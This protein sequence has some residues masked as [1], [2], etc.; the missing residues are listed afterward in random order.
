MGQSARAM[1]HRN[2]SG[3][4]GQAARIAGYISS[5]PAPPALGGPELLP[6]YCAVHPVTRDQLLTTNVHE[7]G[8]LGYGEG[9]VIGHLIPAA[10]VTGRLGVS[11]LKMPW[12]SRFGERVRA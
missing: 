5:D 8:D 11:R 7:P 3:P 12:A 10:P 4:A 2:G 6:L 1:L 9:T